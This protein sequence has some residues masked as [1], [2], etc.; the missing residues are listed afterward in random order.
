MLGE[1]A[2]TQKWLLTAQEKLKGKLGSKAFAQ[3][4]ECIFKPWR[5]RCLIA[6]F[7]VLGLCVGFDIGHREIEPCRKAGNNHYCNN[8]LFHTSSPITVSQVA[9]MRI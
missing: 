7:P 1:A 4:I 9:L 3:S 2:E 8:T 5:H 6:I